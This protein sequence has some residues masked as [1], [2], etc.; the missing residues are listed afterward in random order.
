MTDV[1]RTA[2]QRS[3]RYEKAHNVVVVGNYDRDRSY[4][5]YCMR[6]RGL[7]RMVLVE[8]LLWKHHCGAIHDERQC[9]E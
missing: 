7:D 9:F 6:C 5:P 4:S 8:P 2:D 3:I 1:A